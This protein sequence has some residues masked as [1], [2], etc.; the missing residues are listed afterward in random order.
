MSESESEHPITISGDEKPHPAIRSLARAC[1]A[2]ARL[3]VVAHETPALNIT[4]AAN[5]VEQ[6]DHH[7]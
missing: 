4:P 2:L 6:D 3:R 7:D 5:D 1:I